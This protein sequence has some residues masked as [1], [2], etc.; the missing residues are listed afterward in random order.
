MIETITKIIETS[1]KYAWGIFVVCAFVIFCPE[2]IANEI[3]IKEIHAKY[4]GYWWLL[5]VFSFSICL[6]LFFSGVK[7]WYIKRREIKNRR[8]KT[9]Q[10]KQIIINRLY[11]LNNTEQQW[12]AYCLLNNVQTLHATQINPTANSLLSKRIVTRGPGAIT[13]LPFTIVDF[14]WEHLLVFQNN[15]LPEDI[16]DHPEIIKNLEN[17]ERSLRHIC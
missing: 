14:V 11:Q 5:F 2:N 4:L 7:S 16:E 17:F 15:F 8:T 12:I 3:G 10:N 6:G 1:A 9:E 13:S